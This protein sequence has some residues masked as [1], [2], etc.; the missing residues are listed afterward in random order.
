MPDDKPEYCGVM[1][2]VYRPILAPQLILSNI[3]VKYR[4]IKSG[5]SF[6]P[7]YKDGLFF[8]W[9]LLYKDSD[10]CNGRLPYQIYTKDPQ[11]AASFI[12]EK[13]AEAFIE[14]FRKKEEEYW[15]Y[16]EARDNRIME[17]ITID[18][19]KYIK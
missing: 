19:V 3:M 7:Q 11:Q 1:E 4:I 17:G 13:E 8:G 2:M 16:R 10:I 18:K 6:F 15:A 12:E 14:R 9:T 5:A